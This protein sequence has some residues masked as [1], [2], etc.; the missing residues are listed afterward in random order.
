[1][2]IPG[3]LSLNK[4]LAIRFVPF[5]LIAAV[6]NVLVFFFIQ[7]MVTGEY[8]RVSV[9]QAL[10]MENFIRVRRDMTPPDLQEEA[11]E[12]EAPV[13]EE[14]LP[15]PSMPMP[16]IA[17]PAPSSPVSTPVAGLDININNSA[18][19]NL[20]SLL[21]R[22]SRAKPTAPRIAT[23][24]VPTLRIPPLYPQQ[25]LDAGIDGIVTVQFTIA[26]DG[27]VKDPVI[28][29]ARPKDIFDQAVLQAIRKWKYPPKI[30]NGQP[31]EVRAQTDVTFT[32]DD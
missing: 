19:P 9:N 6:I 21:N 4:F 32:L 13:I 10:D 31:V 7:L 27:S 15:P 24:L 16:Q 23:N 17:P 18:A 25:A 2:R 12:L 22:V 29:K 1:M 14:E 20:D 30:E 11:A 28:V 26:R 8:S 3:L 5:L